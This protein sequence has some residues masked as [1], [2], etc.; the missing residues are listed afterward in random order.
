M[1][2]EQAHKVQCSNGSGS[3]EMSVGVIANLRK[4]VLHL[5]IWQTEAKRE[6]LAPLN[7]FICNQHQEV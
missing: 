7:P 2:H 1:T 4:P 5:D 3:N 6:E